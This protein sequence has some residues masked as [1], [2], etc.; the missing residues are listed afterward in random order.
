MS[1]PTN[2]QYSAEHEW[3][4]LDGDT[5][6]IGVTA[7]AAERT[8]PAT[9][10]VLLGLMSAGSAFGGLAYGSRSWRLPLPQQFAVALLVLG[11][12]I[13]VLALPMNVW[14]FAI[15]SIFAGII[16]A[17]TLTIQS[18]L[19][20]RSAS[21]HHL[22]EAFTWSS[23]GLLAGV[24]AGIEDAREER[25]SPAERQQRLGAPHPGR[26]AGGEHDCGNHRR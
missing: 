11:G 17:P 1:N 5:A 3:V 10:G 12:G 20:A 15:A 8:Q 22:T 13:G 7:Y 25:A 26:F 4:A 2:L 14:W 19:V 16:M 18:M 6:R 9:A 23:T 21:S 24:G